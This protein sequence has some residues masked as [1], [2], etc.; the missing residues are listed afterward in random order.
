MMIIGIFNCVCH[1]NVFLKTPSP[2]TDM[3]AVKTNLKSNPKS[4]PKSNLINKSKTEVWSC[5][6]R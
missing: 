1:L 2:Y 5:Q 6:N 4:N 3:D